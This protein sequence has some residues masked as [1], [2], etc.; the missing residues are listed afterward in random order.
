MS[1]GR[2][3]T[4]F[5]LRAGVRRQGLKI[6]DEQMANFRVE[7]VPNLRACRDLRQ[8]GGDVDHHRRRDGV[9]FYLKA[10]HG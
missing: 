1:L 9:K 3:W 10:T 8:A 2:W 4:M 7:I 6:T 5:Q